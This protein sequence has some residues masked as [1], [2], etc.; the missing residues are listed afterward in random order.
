MPGTMPNAAFSVSYYFY[1]MISSPAADIYAFYS[2]GFA[3]DF[4]T[5]RTVLG[6]RQSSPPP[7][8][9]PIFARAAD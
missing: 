3:R 9:T 4:M 8:T 6:R 5:K 1:F 7:N 2:M